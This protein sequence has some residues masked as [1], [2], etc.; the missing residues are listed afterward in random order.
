M[1]EQ[2][3]VQ[4]A[5]NAKVTELVAFGVRPTN[6]MRFG[7]YHGLSLILNRGRSTRSSSLATVIITKT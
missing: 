7:R 6:S 5:D 2:T 1:A 4:M 3:K